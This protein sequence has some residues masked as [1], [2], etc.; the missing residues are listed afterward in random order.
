MDLCS[1]SGMT[2]VTHIATTAFYHHNV[3]L[4]NNFSMV[5]LYTNSFKFVF[6]A[7]VIGFLVCGNMCMV[8]D[9]YKLFFKPQPVEWYQ[10]GSAQTRSLYIYR[11]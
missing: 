10:K 8:R 5:N 11:Y 9:Q 3:T 7:F 6:I 2:L 4:N 1:I